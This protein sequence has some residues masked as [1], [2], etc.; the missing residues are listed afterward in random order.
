MKHNRPSQRTGIGFD[1]HRLVEGR[2]LV[3]GG[4]EIPFEK[5]LEGHSDADALLHAVCDALL[6]AVARGDIGRHFPNTDERWRNADSGVFVTECARI[7]SECGYRVGN[8]DVT[9]LAEK[10]KI[11][12]HVE[13]MRERIAALLEI[14]E[15]C[16]G[17]KATTMEG[18][19]F[20]GRKE[21]IAAMAVA[22]VFAD[23]E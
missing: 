16:V 8:V 13:K 19:G 5:G 21:G 10:P 1:V 9:V 23:G 15:D 14:P 12:P 3:L 7:V 20:V 22:M 18:M 2:R 6:G 4:V 17:I 11:L